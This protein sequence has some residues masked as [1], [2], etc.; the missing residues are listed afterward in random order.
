MG[1]AAPVVGAA[2]ALA[3]A[4][5]ASVAAADL[6]VVGAAAG[7]SEIG[8]EGTRSKLR[9]TAKPTKYAGGYACLTASRC[10]F[11]STGAPSILSRRPPQL[12]GYTASGL[13]RG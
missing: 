9:R 12:P 11:L 8:P 6:P 7:D 10:G 13:A 4:P 5:A 3:F 2:F 1:S